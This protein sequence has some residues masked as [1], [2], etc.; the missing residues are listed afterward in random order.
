MPR[1]LHTNIVDVMA[2]LADMCQVSVC[3]GLW[4][5]LYLYIH[6]EQVMMM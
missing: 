2:N 5:L 6:H 3:G 4:S 1:N